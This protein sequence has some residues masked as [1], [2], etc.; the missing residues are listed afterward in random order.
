MAEQ[1]TLEYIISGPC[2][3]GVLYGNVLLY[4]EGK[5]LH[6]GRRPTD[7]GMAVPQKAICTMASFCYRYQNA[8][9]SCFLVQIRAFVVLNLAGITKF[10]YERKNERDPSSSEM[11]A[12]CKS[13]ILFLFLFEEKVYSVFDRCVFIG[14]NFESN[15]LYLFFC[16]VLKGDNTEWHYAAKYPFMSWDFSYI[17]IAVDLYTFHSPWAELLLSF[18]WW[19]KIQ[20]KAEDSPVWNNNKVVV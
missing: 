19:L 3:T 15:V 20:A 16:R 13:P 9:V 18:S 11:T 4:S 14:I 6:D 17:Y 12:S 2:D 8:S 10:K 7:R 5:R 1:S